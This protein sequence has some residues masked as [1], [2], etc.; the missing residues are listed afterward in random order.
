[1]VISEVVRAGG[2]IDNLRQFM[3]ISMSGEE[4]LT[5]AEVVAKLRVSRN[6]F[7]IM[8]KNGFFVKPAIDSLKR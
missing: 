5:I 8:R 3:A 6:H 1:M 4:F 7:Y 2:L